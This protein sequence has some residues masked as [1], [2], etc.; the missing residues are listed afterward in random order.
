MTHKTKSR[1]AYAWLWIWLLIVTA[2]A[3]YFYIEIF[4]SA[5]AVISEFPLLLNA[6]EVR[7]DSWITTFLKIVGGVL[8][9]W[10][11][12]KVF[13]LH[14]VPLSFGKQVRTGSKNNV[15]GGRLVISVSICEIS[16]SGRLAGEFLFGVI[17]WV[18]PTSDKLMRTRLKMLVAALPRG[19]SFV[20]EESRIALLKHNNLERT[21]HFL[22]RVP[23]TR[24]SS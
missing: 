7:G 11:A 6:L 1:L 8:F 24:N 19:R 9:C 23:D 20:I 17:F 12:I 13:V 5:V 15:A 14:G 18:H 10:R 3:A 16:H 22:V 4:D 21:K 2:V